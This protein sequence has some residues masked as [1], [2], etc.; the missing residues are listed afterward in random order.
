MVVNSI[1]KGQP[2]FIVLFSKYN[3]ASQTDNQ[4]FLSLCLQASISSS[5]LVVCIH[6]S[7]YIAISWIFYIGFI[8]RYSKSLLCCL[9]TNPIKKIISYSPSIVCE[10]NNVA[11]TSLSQSL[12]TLVDFA[13]MEGLTSTKA[14]M[15]GWFWLNTIIHRIINH[16]YEERIKNGKQKYYK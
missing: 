10:K 12:E 13:S 6:H 5:P 7:F 1:K 2:P 4:I 11:F 15:M 16:H 14:S 9:S 3:H 8:Y